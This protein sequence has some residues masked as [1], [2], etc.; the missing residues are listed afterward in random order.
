LE[1]SELVAEWARGKREASAALALQIAG[2]IKSG[3]YAVEDAPCFC[4]G[5]RDREVALHERYGIP[6]RIV[7]CEEC[8]LLRINPRLTAAAYQSFYNNEYRSLNFPHYLSG[9]ASAEEERQALFDRQIKKG[10][11]LVAKIAEQAI[12]MPKVALD[13]G[14]HLG[15]NL[16]PFRRLG[17]EVWG[18]EIDSDAAAF[19][20]ARGVNVVGSIDELI[21]RGVKADLVIMQD[22]IEHFTDL[23]EV[24]KLG[25]VM[26][27]E[28]YLYVFTPG[29]FRVR[30]AALFQLA[31]TYYFV[32]NTLHWVMAECGFNATYIDEE[33]ESFWQYEGKRAPRSAKPAE[34][35][36]YVAD[37]IEGKD[38]RKMPPFGGVCKFTKKEL[39]DNMQKNFARQIPDLY[40][41]TQSRTGPVAILAGGPSVDEQ[42]GEIKRLADSGVPVMAIAR[43]YPWCAMHGIKPE[44][45]VSL[46]CM[47]EQEKGFVLLQP[48]VTYLLAAVTRPAIVER[49]KREKIY[50]FDSRDDV[51]VQKLRREAGY[52]VCSVVNGGGS[53]AV[54]SISL[55]FNLGFRE[56]HVFGMDLM[57]RS[58]EQTHATGIAGESVEVRP[59]P[60]TIKGEDIQTTGPWLEFARQ[61]LD[62]L[63][64]AH[65][66]GI[67]DSVKFYGESLINKMWDGKFYDEDAA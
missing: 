30:A 65:N 64:A 42:A 45:V 24:A 10:E 56:L 33:C 44:Y 13:V 23:R 59:L 60:V 43:M 66:D 35:V 17:S 67:L 12:A 28:S 31:H 34:W 49:V 18:I 21:E 15:G 1:R 55:A 4:G 38:E 51:Y 11:R 39:Y 36:E 5:A 14:C 52:T 58:L 50:I 3:E 53:V 6:A 26:T 62:L 25:A 47:D 40:A 16:E 27:P 19:A 29:L 54:L 63:S 46:D 8:A 37:E 41:I 22:V 32:A 57:T 7:L 20:E 2:K 48:G 61:T 9:V